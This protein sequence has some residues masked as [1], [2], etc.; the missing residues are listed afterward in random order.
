MTD[1]RFWFGWIV[2]MFLA[3]SMTAKV[4]FDEKATANNQ[5]VKLLKV[6]AAESKSK[7]FHLQNAIDY[8][9]RTSMAW[10]QKHK[11]FTCHTN[12]LHL[13]AMSDFR[14]KPKYFNAVH[15]S[16]N[17][18]VTQRWKEKGPRWDAEVVMAAVTLALVDRGN[19]TRL[20]PAAKI[21]VDRVWEVQRDDGGFDWL[22][23]DWP[24]MESDDEFGAAMAAVGL[25]AVP[26]NYL[27]SQAA[28]AGVA[29]LKKYIRTNAIQK[30]HNRA[31]LVW[32]NR[33]GGDWISGLQVQKTVNE[34]VSLQKQD[35][36]W[37]TPSM[38]KWDRVDGQDPDHQTSDG[39]ATGLAVFVLLRSGLGKDHESVREGIQW[40]KNN[41]R[42]SGRW[43]TRSV[44]K[45]SK[46]YLTHA[47][48]ALAIMALKAGE[49]N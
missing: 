42:E 29:K 40:L 8:L 27:E 31:L 19:G 18:M 30:L 24:P 17:Q 39:Y 25:S 7:T 48:T 36:G 37:N 5:E 47:G 14:Q 20:S 1:T 41:Q 2:W 13:I 10:T 34:L 33:L 32:A 45:G 22:K 6:D 15:Q 9:D 11:C 43:Y 16:L 12:Y 49:E 23:C 38:G 3:S 21:A 28:K 4:P 26:K 46:H 44:S 35:G